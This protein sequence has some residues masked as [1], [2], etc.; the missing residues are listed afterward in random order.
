MYGPKTYCQTKSFTACSGC[1]GRWPLALEPE[2]SK[3]RLS[4]LPVVGERALRCPAGLHAQGLGY[5]EA[6]VRGLHRWKSPWSLSFGMRLE[7]ASIEQMPSSFTQGDG[8]LSLP[9]LLVLFPSPTQPPK[10]I[11]RLCLS[12]LD[13]LSTTTNSVVLLTARHCPL[14]RLSWNLN[15]IQHRT[16]Q[17]STMQKLP[18][19]ATLLYTV[20]SISPSGSSVARR[21]CT[22]TRAPSRCCAESR[23][24]HGVHGGAL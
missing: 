20:N 24:L 17:C 7:V 13:M 5:G 16:M 8:K 10:H 4:T 9:K 1:N 2:A 18:C 23:E 21:R 15:R 12:K 11:T 3:F 22:A 14:H 6:V 19:H